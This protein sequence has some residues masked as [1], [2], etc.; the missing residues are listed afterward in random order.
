MVGNFYLGWNLRP[1]VDTFEVNNAAILEN[2]GGSFMLQQRVGGEEGVRWCQL[3][4]MYV[5]DLESK[6]S[7][8]L[9]PVQNNI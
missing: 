2:C 7:R 9:L 1:V 3:Y 5:Q 4:V 6:K 8:F